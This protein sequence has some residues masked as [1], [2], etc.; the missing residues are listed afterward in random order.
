MKK[1]LFI[2]LTFLFILRVNAYEND[3]FKID[4]PEEYG[5]PTIED[6]SYKWTEGNHYI[7]I[8]VSSN[9]ETNYNI[10]TYDNKEIEKQKGSIEEKVNK[11]IEK[12]NI[13]SEVLSIKK[14]N[15]GELYFLEYS[16]HYPTKEIIGYDLYQAGR[17]YTTKNYVI[18]VIF[19]N[20]K[21]VTDTEVEELFKNFDIKDN[22]K[23][24]KKMTSKQLMYATAIVGFLLALASSL[25]K[26]IKN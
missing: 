17:M 23:V 21:E 11:G 12:Y 25:R 14:N 3:I 26:K 7:A 9:K 20:D 10:K 15:K 18:T 16:I 4:I 19:N 1:I 24:T 2:L 22:Y 5:E 6:N 13:K 8:T